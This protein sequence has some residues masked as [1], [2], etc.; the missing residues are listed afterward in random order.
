MH[1]EV[2]KGKVNGC[3]RDEGS[4]QI[5]AR[6]P[7]AQFEVEVDAIVRDQRCRAHRKL[8]EVLIRCLSVAKIGTYH[9]M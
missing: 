5:G 8:R 4:N 3:G 2:V 7:S 9:K 1:L 6:G